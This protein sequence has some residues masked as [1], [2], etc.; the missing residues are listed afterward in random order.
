[1]SESPYLSIQDLAE[2]WRCSVQTIY[3][4][5]NEDKLDLPAVTEGKG[6]GKRV[7]F[8]RTDVEAY[9]RTWLPA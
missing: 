6:R 5:R 7:L 1:M 4:R 3:N 8:R 2:R 9:E